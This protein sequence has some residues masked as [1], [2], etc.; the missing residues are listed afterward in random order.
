LPMCMV[1]I[2]IS[3]RGPA[4]NRE[5]LQRGL[6]R[7]LPY[8]CIG[9]VPS[10]T[11]GSTKD[12]RCCIQPC[13]PPGGGSAAHPV[14]IGELRLTSKLTRPQ[15]V[16]PP[17]STAARLKPGSSWPPELVKTR[18]KAAQDRS[19]TIECLDEPHHVAS[20]SSYKHVNHKR[21]CYREMMRCV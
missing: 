12:C 16:P 6:T 3:A 14:W 18:S 13:H 17:S 2:A 15:P 19:N 4:Y 11:V 7:P 1:C 8:C 20:A 9:S 5:T 10:M 21:K